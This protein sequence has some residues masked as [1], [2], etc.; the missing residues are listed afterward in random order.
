MAQTARRITVDWAKALAEQTQIGHN[1]WH[2]DIPPIIEVEPGEQIEL[3]TLDGMDGQIRETSTVADVAG[4]SG[5]RVHPLTGP[6]YVKGAEPGDL[7]EI[8]ID[9]VEPADFGYT[10][11]LTGFGYL[12]DLFPNPFLVKW[13]MADGYAESD[14][15]PGIRIK[16]FPFM[17]VIGLAPSRDLLRTIIEREQ[18]LLERGGAVNPPDPHEAIPADPHIANEAIRTLAPHEVG[19]N[20]DVKQMTAGTRLFIPVGVPGALFSCGD[21]HFAQGDGEVCG[22]AIEMQGTF[23]GS[24]AVHKGQAARRNLRDVAFS[25]DEYFMDP[26]LAAPRRFFATTGMSISRDGRN[27]S[28]DVSLAARNALI[29]MIEHLT[30]TRDYSEQQAYAICS[31]AVDL[32]VSEVVDVPN[33]VV[34]ALLPL[35]IFI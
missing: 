8:R 15:L 28:E 33:P 17:G 21:A 14:A 16:G 4:S 12:R 30:T 18:E 9:Q 7:L 32:R 31:V 11:Q 3:E 2:P 29:N 22:T 5:T 25:R 24:F 34:S 13:H 1:R 23:H 10:V 35:D 6:V 19:G 26:D 27:H 20:L